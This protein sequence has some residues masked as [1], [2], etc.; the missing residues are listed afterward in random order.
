M[1][2]PRPDTYH[3][4]QKYEIDHSRNP[5]FVNIPNE[6]KQE[7]WNKIE[8]DYIKKY[9]QFVRIDFH[10]GLSGIWILPFPGAIFSG[11]V[12]KEEDFFPLPKR[13]SNRLSKW[14]YYIE[15]NAFLDDNFNWDAAHK[16]GTAIAI[17][18]RKYVPKNIYMEY[19]GFKQIKM[20]KGVAVEL[21]IPDFLKIYMPHSA[22]VPPLS[23][24]SF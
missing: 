15:Q 9:K 4:W 19:G 12:E 6:K 24:L 7:I 2:T 18:I 13:L 17:E 3:H 22:E 21:D 1:K 8:N 20:I 23:P 14:V 16:E 11:T 5:L 10:W